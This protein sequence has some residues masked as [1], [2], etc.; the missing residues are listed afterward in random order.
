MRDAT[1]LLQILTSALAFRINKKLT[2]LVTYHLFISFPDKP[3][4][5]LHPI[6]RTVFENR[7]ETEFNCEADGNAGVTHYMW[8]QYEPIP[9]QDIDNVLKTDTDLAKYVSYENNRKRL[10]FVKPPR[11]YRGKYFCAGRND[12]GT[13]K[14]EG[15]YLNVTC[16]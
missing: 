4:L 14:A 9:S 10:K 16:K 11:K 5:T 6:N 3:V 13:G 8:Y 15:A 12:L 7:G 1:V 2:K